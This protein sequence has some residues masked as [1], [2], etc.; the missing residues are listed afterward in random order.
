MTDWSA[1]V[2]EFGPVVWQTAYRLLGDHAEAGD[3][4]QET[5]VAAF[6]SYDHEPVEN[7][8]ALLKRIATNRA[9][10]QLR[11]RIQHDKHSERLRNGINIS[12]S[13]PGP[14]EEAEKHDLS[15]RLRLALAKLPEREAEL[16]CLRYLHDWSHRRIAEA[17]GLNQNSVGSLLYRARSHLRRLLRIDP[18]GEKSVR[19]HHVR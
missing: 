19:C 7:W 12:C 5:F 2:H 10:N 13:N 11:K 16:L 6:Q 18:D 15:N 14:D 17:T 4:F 8:S 1:I 3:C 9:I